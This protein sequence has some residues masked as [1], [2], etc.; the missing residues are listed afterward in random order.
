LYDQAV[1]TAGLGAV[2]VSSDMLRN[3]YDRYDAKMQQSFWSPGKLWWDGR[4][5]QFTA[6][7]KWILHALLMGDDSRLRNASAADKNFFKEELGVLPFKEGQTSISVSRPGEVTEEFYRKGAI[8]R[9]EAMEDVWGDVEAWQKRLGRKKA[10]GRIKEL[11]QKAE[12]PDFVQPN[13]QLQF[14]Y[15]V[16]G[17]DKPWTAGQ[18][19]LKP[20]TTVHRPRA[21]YDEVWIIGFKHPVSGTEYKFKDPVDAK[22]YFYNPAKYRGE[23]GDKIY[24]NDEGLVYESM[25]TVKDPKAQERYEKELEELGEMKAKEIE[26]FRQNVAKEPFIRQAGASLAGGA[27]VSGQYIKG[28][29]ASMAGGMRVQ[30]TKK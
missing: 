9:R 5:V 17:G 19:D 1:E 15:R 8:K 16:R 25:D 24:I 3:N 10:S 22:Y 28:G 4:Y 26:L 6:V 23:L 21:Y 27:P 13:T 11:Q 7:Q 30:P 12:N 2:A 29:R 18:Y 14:L 20:T